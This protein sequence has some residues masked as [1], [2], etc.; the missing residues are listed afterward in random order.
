MNQSAGPADQAVEDTVALIT[1]E[2]QSGI[3]RLIPSHPMPIFRGF[4]FPTK[5]GKYAGV[6]RRQKLNLYSSTFGGNV[7]DVETSF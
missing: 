4:P 3:A 1:M 6:S 7:S 5:R 2:D